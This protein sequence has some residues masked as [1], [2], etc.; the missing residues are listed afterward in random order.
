[1]QR[2]VESAYEYHSY[3]KTGLNLWKNAMKY[4]HESRGKQ[5][6][7]PANNWN[8][9]IDVRCDLAITLKKLAEGVVNELVK[10]VG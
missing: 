5:K 7:Y 2:V 6:E 1:M 9:P 4:I 10:G 8:R 3:V